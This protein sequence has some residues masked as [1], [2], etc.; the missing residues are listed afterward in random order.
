MSSEDAQQ[1]RLPDN[2]KDSPHNQDDLLAAVGGWSWE[3]AG[4]R[5]VDVLPLSGEDPTAKE[6]QEGAV[7]EAA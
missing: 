1:N 6:S 7:A 2:E 5:P 4:L 3:G